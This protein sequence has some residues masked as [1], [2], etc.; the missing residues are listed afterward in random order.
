[1][2]ASSPNRVHN[3]HL[4]GELLDGTVIQ[5]GETFS[6]N[7]V[8]GPRTP[9]RGFLEGQ[10]IFAG[11]LIPS[12]GGG[13]CQTG[14]TIFNAAFEAGL[15]ITERTNHSF[16]ISH[17]PIGRD[18]TVSWGGPDLVFKNDLEHP[19]LLHTEWTDETF[20]VSLFGTGQ[21]RTV[22]SE[23]SKPKSFTQPKLQFAID[24]TAPPKSVRTTDGGGPGFDVNV[25][26]K[27]FEDGKLLREDDFPTRYTPENP[28]R[29][30]GPKAKAPAGAFVLPTTG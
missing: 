23:T 22:V 20:T 3:V 10:M 4:M 18:A 19:I 6:F 2:G 9:E 17:Y 15:P 29:V 11:V 28:T 5:P 24:P 27:V 26:R 12:I 16:Y 14:T 13:V 30:Y 21:S 8:V 7:R 1:M 25:H